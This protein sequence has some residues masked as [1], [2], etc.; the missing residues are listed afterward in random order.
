MQAQCYV[1]GDYDPYDFAPALTSHSGFL[2]R[3]S[4]PLWKTV[5]EKA[6][7]AGK[8]NIHETSGEHSPRK[9]KGEGRGS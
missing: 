5:E 6:I 4:E 3:S 1:K 2:Q 7:A 8:G 9:G